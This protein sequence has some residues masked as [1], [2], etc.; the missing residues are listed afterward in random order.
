MPEIDRSRAPDCRWQEAVRR[1]NNEAP[2]HWCSDALADRV[3][4][5]LKLQRQARTGEARARFEEKF[6]TIAQAQRIRF[7]PRDGRRDAIEVR[8]LAGYPPGRIAELS[9]LSPVVVWV[10]LALF[11]D[12]LDRL[13][14][15]EFVWSQVIGFQQDD[16][17]DLTREQK[18]MRWL[19]WTCGPLAADALLLPGCDVGFAE[20][21][22]D[23]DEVLIEATQALVARAMSLAPFVDRIDGEQARQIMRWRI[24]ARQ[25]R[26]ADTGDLGQRQ[27][28]ENVKAFM[29]SIELTIGRSN[30]PKGV[31]EKYFTSHVEPRAEEWAAIGRGDPVPEFDA[32]VAATASMRSRGGIRDSADDQQEVQSADHNGRSQD[33]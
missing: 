18:A 20:R 1:V 22:G 15:P 9:A 31:D 21:N 12:I 23:I 4:T 16:E 8:L 24:Q 33:E 28:L 11:F 19:A 32:K 14:A 5:F 27:Y 26:E 13:D 7:D 25:L 29:D 6:P 10:Y 2:A 3:I 30:I 17:G